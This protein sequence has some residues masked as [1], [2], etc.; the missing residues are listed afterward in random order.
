M[1]SPPRVLLVG[2]DGQIGWELR[3]CLAPCASVVAIDLPEIDLTQP[4]SIRKWVADCRPEVIINAAAHTA[5]DQAESEPD[6]C[7][8]INGVAPGIL[9]EE[10][11]R[12][13]AWMIHYSTDYVFDGRASSPYLESDPPNPL[14]AYGRS[15]LA[16]DAAVQ[17]ACGRHLILRLCWVYGWRGQNFLLTMQRLARERDHIKVV[18]DQLG[19]PTWSRLVAEAT[20]FALRQV[21]ATRDSSL[22]G[23]YHLCSSSHTSWHGF[24]S[25][26]IRGMPPKERTCTRV[27]PIPTAEYPT[28]ATRPVWSVLSCAKLERV[29][30]LRLPGWEEGLGL[31]LESH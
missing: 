21:L 5:V 4:G 13:G 26:I 24:A 23:L 1:P 30:G 18:S 2:R 9:A 10:A 27:L 11:A 29:F 3:R 7:M 8:A 16:G 15:K 6:R 17:S 12:H 25:A 22:S 19:C 31:A 14:N 20:A 28:R